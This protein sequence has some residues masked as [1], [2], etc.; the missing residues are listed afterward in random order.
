MKPLLFIDFH[1]TLSN[2]YFWSSQS[3]DIRQKIEEF[4]FTTPNLAT[5]DWM[6]GVYSSEEV[7]QM[8]AEKFGL[9]PEV[10]WKT[11]VE[12]CKKIS[13]SPELLGLIAD[14][15]NKYTVILITDNMDCFPRFTVPFIGLTKHF[16]HIAV[17]SEE[18]IL[19]NEKEGEWFRRL[20]KKFNSEMSRSILIDNSKSV[21]RLFDSLGGRAFLV[22]DEQSTAYWLLKVHTMV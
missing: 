9:E 22:T 5:R 12:D 15:R 2:D 1:G 14:V 21:C 18:K 8:I 17:S 4:L 19:K 7:N 10:L 11:F 20:V 6:K 16:D 3:R 13:V